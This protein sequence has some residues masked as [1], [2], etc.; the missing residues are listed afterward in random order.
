[1]SIITPVAKSGLDDLGPLFEEQSLD[2]VWD[3]FNEEYSRKFLNVLHR[4]EYSLRLIFPIIAI[5]RFSLSRQSAISR[6]LTSAQILTVLD[7]TYDSENS[8]LELQQNIDEMSETSQWEDCLLSNVLIRGCSKSDLT[9]RVMVN[10]LRSSDVAELTRA[11][12]T[13]VNKI[14]GVNACDIIVHHLSTRDGFIRFKSPETLGV[15]NIK[16]ILSQGLYDLDDFIV[17][18]NMHAATAGYGHFYTKVSQKKSDKYL[19]VFKEALA[20]SEEDK[21]FDDICDDPRILH[22]DFQIEL[23]L[24]GNPDVF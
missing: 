24:I 23:P 13:K 15:D 12:H 14:T 18:A 7:G 3:E 16:K 19:Q 9:G 2:N 5:K 20:H 8:S 22:E 6:Q 1:M 4:H 21:E 10:L 11:T 17:D